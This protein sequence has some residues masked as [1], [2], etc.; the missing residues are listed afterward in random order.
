MEGAGRGPA[1]RSATGPV[2]RA[3]V[4]RGPTA[5]W[6]R[7]PRT[8]GPARA[9][10][11]SPPG[12]PRAVEGGGARRRGCSRLRRFPVGARGGE[13]GTRAPP[14]PRPPPERVE[15]EREAEPRYLVLWLVPQCFRVAV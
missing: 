14:P 1:G 13:R 5:G 10:R 9:P 4:G 2:P 12:P 11:R 7:R 8:P 3:E 15:R 6:R